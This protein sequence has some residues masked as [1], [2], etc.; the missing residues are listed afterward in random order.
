M[1]KQLVIIGIIALLVTV[2]FS[3]C[4][5]N[6][7]SETKIQITNIE[8][9]ESFIYDEFYTDEVSNKVYKITAT[10]KNTGSVGSDI[11]LA[12]ILNEGHG[13]QTEETETL[14]DSEYD[15]IYLDP[16]ESIT[17]TKTLTGHISAEAVYFG[18]EVE[19]KISGFTVDAYHSKHFWIEV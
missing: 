18:V 5:D 17:K 3:G 1:N 14:Q 8:V 12:F 13:A 16:G 9:D 11:E 2:G 7:E 15:S 10:F 4:T 19:A 6:T